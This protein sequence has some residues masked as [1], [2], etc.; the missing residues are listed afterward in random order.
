[1]IHIRITD[2]TSTSDVDELRDRVHEYN[3]DTTGYRDG[4]SLSCFLRD[5]EGRLFAGIDGFT[6]GGYA[7]IEYLWVNSARRGEEIGRRLLT[8]AE[9]E[10]RARGCVVVRVDSHAFQAP[11]FYRKH[12]YDEIGFAADAPVGYG[13]YFFE[14]R[15]NR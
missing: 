13:E 5:A 12:G 15:L 10:A 6:W 7:K 1:V 8:A 4:R 2:I 9:D 3:F 14:K 11:D